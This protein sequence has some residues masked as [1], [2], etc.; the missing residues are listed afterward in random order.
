MSRFLINNIHCW[1]IGIFSLKWTYT[2][3]DLYDFHSQQNWYFDLNPI[4]KQLK[5]WNKMM[6]SN[7]WYAILLNYT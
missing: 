5:K 2:A 3:I 4:R 7:H 6:F 1:S